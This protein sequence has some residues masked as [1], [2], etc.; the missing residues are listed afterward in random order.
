[1]ALPGELPRPKL[2]EAEL[3]VASLSVPGGVAPVTPATPSP[4]VAALEEEALPPATP[5]ATPEP[6]PSRAAPG[7]AIIIDDLGEHP[8]LL[9][10]ALSI[11]LPLT[12]AVIPFLSH[13]RACART[14]A[15]QGR[16]VILHLP[17]EPL[18]YPRHDPGPRA[19]FRGQGGDEAKRRTRAALAEVPEARG[20]NNHMGSS[21]TRDAKLMKSVLE[22]IRDERLFFVDSRTAEDSIAYRV[23][24]ELGIPSA[25]RQVFLDRDDFDEAFTRQQLR[26]LFATARREG[27]AIGI[28]HWHETTLR[29]VREEARELAGDDVR[30]LPASAFVSR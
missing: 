5:A 19:V 29:I 2:P 30:I 1:M 23:A 4:P 18:S 28:G 7:C 10:R 12:F 27:R 8:E 11:D 9:P 15:S 24:R 20:V 3:V 13:T 17:M 26:L 6:P 22:V 25:E 21:A 16:E 14:L